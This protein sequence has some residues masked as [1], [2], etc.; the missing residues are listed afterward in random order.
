MH[1]SAE[2]IGAIALGGWPAKSCKGQ[3]LGWLATFGIVGAFIAGWLFPS[4]VFILVLGTAGPCM[5]GM[6]NRPVDPNQ[7]SGAICV[8]ACS[9]RQGCNE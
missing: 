1:L 5:S 4:S 8:R 3:A 6:R 9:K 2:L 7:P